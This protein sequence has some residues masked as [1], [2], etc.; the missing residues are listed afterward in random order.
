[1]ASLYSAQKS[2]F[3][4]QRKPAN[5]SNAQSALRWI[6][7]RR[8]HGWRSARIETGCLVERGTDSAQCVRRYRC[9]QVFRP[10]GPH[11]QEDTCANRA[12]N[13]NAQRALR[14]VCGKRSHGWRS[15]RIETGCLVEGKTD[16]AQCGRR[17]ISN[18][19]PCGFSR[20]L[21]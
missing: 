11:S 19:K 21:A 3:R 13:I 8:S 17:E 18:N 7:G 14:W 9:L 20:S 4:V 2:L 16:L 10:S 12:N 6:C 5:T 15:A 1:M